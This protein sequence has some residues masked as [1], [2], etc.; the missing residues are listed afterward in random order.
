MKR[1][2]FLTLIG[3]VISCESLITSLRNPCDSDFTRDELKKQVGFYIWAQENAMDFV[4][5]STLA[6]FDEE[7][8]ILLQ[9]RAKEY[10]QSTNIEE[11]GKPTKFGENI[12]KCSAV[13]ELKGKRYTVVYNVEKVHSGKENYYRVELQDMLEVR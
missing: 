1:A 7:S 6:F 3:L 5:G 10:I 12:Y 4:L 13:L 8:T 11:I 2:V 9:E